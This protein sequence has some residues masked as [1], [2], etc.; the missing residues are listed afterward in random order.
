MEHCFESLRNWRKKNDQEETSVDQML[1]A[2]VLRA[3]S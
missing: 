3:E 2:A 1:Q